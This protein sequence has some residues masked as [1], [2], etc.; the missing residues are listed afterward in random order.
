MPLS[1]VPPVNNPPSTDDI[2]PYAQA[3]LN[4]IR[5][6][7]SGGVGDTVVDRGGDVIPS[8][9]KQIADDRATL[10][11]S[12]QLTGMPA[13]TEAAG[14]AAVADLVW[15]AYFSGS[16]NE[17]VVIAQRDAGGASSTVKKTYPSK[18]YVDALATLVAIAQAMATEGDVPLLFPVGSLVQMLWSAGL[19]DDGYPGAWLGT[20]GLLRFRDADSR[21]NE[22]LLIDVVAP[23]S[24]VFIVIDEDGYM[25][26]AWNADPTVSAA[27]LTNSVIATLGASGNAVIDLITP[28]LGWLIA[29]EDGYVGSSLNVDQGISLTGEITR[30][31]TVFSRGASPGRDIVIIDAT[32][33]LQLTDSVMGDGDNYQPLGGTRNIRWVKGAAGAETFQVRPFTYRPVPAATGVTALMHIISTGQSLDLG[34]EAAPQ[35]YPPLNPGRA[36]MFGGLGGISPGWYYVAGVGNTNNAALTDD[37]EFGPLVDAKAVNSETIGPRLMSGLVATGP[38]NRAYL[39]SVHGSNGAS[40][41]NIKKGGNN[42]QYRNSLRAIVLARFYA[43]LAGIDYTV[44]D[45]TFVHGEADRADSKATYLAKILELHDNYEADIRRLSGKPAQNLRMYL[46]QTSGWCSYGDVYSAVPLAQ[47]QCALDDPAHYT[48]IGPKYYYT[49]AAGAG[50]HII[51]SQQAKHG[52]YY[53]R[54]KAVVDAGGT[55][56]PMYPTAAARS[57]TSVSVTVNVP[58]GAL[59]L[60]TALVTDPGNY[61]VTY[62]DGSGNQIVVSGVSIAGSTINFTIAT[63]IAGKAQ[64]GMRKPG[65]AGVAVSAGPTTGCRTC[66]RDSAAAV[67]AVDGSR[68]YN[69]MSHSEIAVA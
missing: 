9:Q 19:D 25:G 34:I 6:R 40:Y 36:L 11:A 29:D 13:A 59:T 51:G 62:E 61:G 38:A 67:S 10:L 4:V 30:D 64:F 7:A 20:D 37:S 60:D 22:Y 5:V 55:W 66:F 47:L 45:M 56:K 21:G 15:F 23:S 44:S 12:V 42:S 18:A 17:S 35:S 39:Y 32:Q 46:C 63:A 24:D 41:A 65:S 3:D 16:A 43:W 27:T 31:Y 53:A 28:G 68:L 69:W 50:V 2:G 14:R 26:Y 49:Y 52:E 33:S 48:C 58:E 54:A 57:G 8:I 1:S